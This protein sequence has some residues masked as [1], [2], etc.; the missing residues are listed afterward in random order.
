[1]P[2]TMPS[3]FSFQHPVTQAAAIQGIQLLGQFWLQSRLAKISSGPDL[4]KEYIDK[5]DQLIKKIEAERNMNKE[6]TPVLADMSADISKEE[7]AALPDMSAHINMSAYTNKEKTAAESSTAKGI[8]TACLPCTRAHLITVAGTLKE[9]LRF[10]RDEGLNHPEV[11][12]RLDAAAEEIAVM[13]RFDLAPERI[14]NAPPEEKEVI[15]KVLPQIRNLRQKLINEIDSVEDLE[16]TAA[17]AAE[18]YKQARNT[19][20]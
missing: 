7:T 17:T 18:I 3:I 10:A 1:M 13:E 12:D 4:R 8:A 20:E 16:E 6:R 14:A 5:L 2:K 11:L 15:R 19:G 9:A